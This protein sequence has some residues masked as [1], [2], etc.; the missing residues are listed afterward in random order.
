MLLY[1]EE[2]EYQYIAYLLYD[3][4]SNDNNGEVDT[5]EQT[6]L[7]NSLPWKIKCFFRDA[8]SQTID[9]TNNLSSIDKLQIPLEL[10]Q[11]EHDL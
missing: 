1:S 10:R 9:Y 3:L 7:L 8:M 11:L 2:H 4:L 6:M 5:T